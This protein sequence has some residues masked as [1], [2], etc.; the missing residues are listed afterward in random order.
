VRDAR[1]QLMLCIGGTANKNKD[2]FELR[3][4]ELVDEIRT[5]LKVSSKTGADTP[6]TSLAGK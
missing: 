1:G 6:V 5:E 3:F 2:A 4:R